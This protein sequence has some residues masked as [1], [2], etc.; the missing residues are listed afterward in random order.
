MLMESAEKLCDGRLMATH[1]GGYN[2]TYSPFCGLFVM[3]QL[4]GI[5]KLNDPFDHADRYPGQELKFH[6]REIIEKARALVDEI[7]SAD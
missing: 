2:A 7:G 5:T 3:Q 1:E 4:S 6:E